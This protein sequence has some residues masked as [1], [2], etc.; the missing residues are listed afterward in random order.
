VS[1]D[2]AQRFQQGFDAGT[3]VKR[4][5]HWHL[6]LARAVRQTLLQAGLAEDGIDVL[7]DCTSCDAERFFSHRRDNGVTGRHLNFAVCRF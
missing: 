6:D 7:R 4:D 5:G 2:L 1:E 3:A